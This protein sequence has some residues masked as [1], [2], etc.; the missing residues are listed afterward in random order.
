M[1]FARPSFIYVSRRPSLMVLN[2]LERALLKSWSPARGE[3][4]ARN[5]ST[6][7]RAAAA[8]ARPRLEL[9]LAATRAS[10]SLTR[11]RL[12]AMTTS[13]CASAT[14]GLDVSRACRRRTER[15][16]RAGE[17]GRAVS[18]RAVDVARRG[19]GHGDVA[20]GPA[21][22]SGAAT[23]R[24]RWGVVDA[25]ARGGATT[26]TPGARENGAFA[27]RIDGGF[28]AESDVFEGRVR[29]GDV[30][31]ARAGASE[32]E[33]EATG[34]KPKKVSNL[35]KRTLSAL[36]LGAIGAVVIF[37]GGWPWAIAMALFNG[38]AAMEYFDMVTGMRS[39]EAPYPPPKWCIN[40]CAA[41]CASLPIILHFTG[42]RMTSIIAATVISLF[43][44]FAL[45][46]VNEEAHFNEF[47]SSLFGL[48]YAGF[49]PTFWVKLRGMSGVAL[50]SPGSLV[51]LWPGFLGGPK[52]WSLGLAATLTIVFAVVA[53]DVGA[54]A[55]GKTLGK[56][57][58]TRVSPNKTVEGAVGGLLACTGTCAG[59]FIIMGWPGNPMQGAMLGVMVFFTS[60]FG[61]L[62]ES[63]MKRNAGM[64][65]SGT[66]I[67]G[68]GGL[69]D[70]FDSYI[71]TG[72]VTYFF[73][74]AVLGGFRKIFSVGY[75]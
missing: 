7:A 14:P 74:I 53:A 43:V 10:L 50:D 31:L 61:D 29:R 58:L 15:V 1:R 19:V 24:R 2:R 44:I 70:R 37:A 33:V 32:G 68:H 49:L 39:C 38:A 3:R 75:Y 63:V 34:A 23:S 35:L 55:F 20:L 56:N 16:G 62:L 66:L 22:G 69:L 72:S 4:D 71:F 11:T 5:R 26:R 36:L 17:G 6:N 25:R 40:L 73:T 45:L 57:K 30:A 48:V 67:P 27:L 59:L 21:R 13:V 54:Y 12:R 52:V 42:G 46:I 51:H 18:A 41:V 8:H 65:D 64:K 60:I 47:S 9:E 28:G